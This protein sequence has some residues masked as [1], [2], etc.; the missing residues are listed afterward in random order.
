MPNPI[1]I[2]AQI[3]AARAFL[4]WS[5]EQLAVAAE[6]GINSV[7]DVESQKRPADSGAVT[8]IKRALENAG[9]IFLTA[10]ED[11]GPGVRLAANRP[12]LVR[13][14]TVVMK[15]EGVPFEIEWRGRAYTAFVSYEVLEDLGRLTNPTDEQLLRSFAMHKARILDE[16]G[17]AIQ[18][19]E[20][21]DKRGFLHLRGSDF[22]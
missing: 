13:R 14:P 15:W 18:K 22:V 17:K 11:E 16:V 8:S 21:F 19:P 9:L 10:D 12:N 4:D 1:V 20:N 6:V 5:Q 7:R 2:P 3:R